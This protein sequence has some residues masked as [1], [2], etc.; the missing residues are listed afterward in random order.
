MKEAYL[1]VY[2]PNV[3]GPKAQNMVPTSLHLREIPSDIN[4]YIYDYM[5]LLLIISNDIDIVD[6]VI[7]VM[8]HMI[9]IVLIVD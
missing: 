7:H 3:Y 6:I 9:M 1:R 2:T 4:I 8:D 5:I